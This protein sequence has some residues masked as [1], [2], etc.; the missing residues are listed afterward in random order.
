M[1]ICSQLAQKEY[2]TW[3][4]WVGKV[5]HWELCKRLKLDNS[6]KWH[7]HKPESVLEN[8]THKILWNFEIQMDHLILTRTPDQEDFTVLVDPSV[9]IKE[10][11]K[12]DKYL[13]LTRELKK[14]W[15]LRVKVIPV[16][17]GALETVSRSQEKG[18]EELEISG[19]IKTIQIIA[20]LRLDRILRRVL[21][22]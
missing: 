2:K 17:F 22:I 19:R 5:I 4:D 18:L 12:I 9:K 1:S 16:V 21:E 10:S 8:E 13:D 11:E 3:H 6:T 7:M 20:L 14:L 15:N